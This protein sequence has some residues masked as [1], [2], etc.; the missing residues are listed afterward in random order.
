MSV[1]E[2]GFGITGCG[3]IANFHATAL[4]VIL[5]QMLEEVTR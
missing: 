3:M 2:L 4:N 5:K 1:K